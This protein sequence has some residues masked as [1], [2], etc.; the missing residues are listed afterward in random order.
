MAYGIS[1]TQ[2]QYDTPY[3]APT[4]GFFVGFI[5]S[6]PSGYSPKVL[7]YQ[8]PFYGTSYGTPRY[9]FGPTPVYY[10]N[11][12]TAVTTTLTSTAQQ[13]GVVG[14]ST[15][16]ATSL[17]STATRYTTLGASTAISTTLTADALHAEFAQELFT[18]TAGLTSTAQLNI[19]V[20]STTAI[21]AGLSADSIVTR[22]ADASTALTTALTSAGIHIE[23]AN[24]STTVTA[25]LSAAVIKGV[26][27]DS[28][29]SVTEA[30][31]NQISTL[32]YTTTQPVSIT[33]AFTAAINYGQALVAQLSSIFTS[34]AKVKKTNQYTDHDI[35]VFGQLLPRRWDSDLPVSRWVGD[36][37]DQRN[38]AAS[39]PTKRWASG[40]LTDRNKFATLADR[41][42]RGNLQ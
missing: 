26:V 21:N 35:V 2:L 41:R 12:A 34:S 13:N 16:V 4:P 18:A 31:N 15:A 5:S 20:Q 23:N 22:Y 19:K 37:G 42:W 27:A 32:Y 7:S 1:Y 14:S 30:S 36:L 29:L 28:Q 40:I 10:A 6:D 17:T 33:S 39:L 24:T 25:S 38:W 3:F 11:V 9:Y 8:S